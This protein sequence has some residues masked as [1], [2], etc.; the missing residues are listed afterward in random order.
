[1]NNQNFLDNKGLT[2][3]QFSLSTG[4][5]ELNYFGNEVANIS[6]TPTRRIDLLPGT[7]RISGGELFHIAPGSPMPPT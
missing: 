3:L 7:Y 4:E 2:V 5:D 6:L 1:M